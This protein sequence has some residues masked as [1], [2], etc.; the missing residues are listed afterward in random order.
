MKM[1]CN[2]MWVLV[3]GIVLVA[4]A[5]VEAAL[6]D[7]LK[8]YWNFD[9]GSGTT[10]SDIHGDVEGVATLLGSPTWIAGKVGSGAVDFNGNNQYANVPPSMDN[11]DPTYTTSITV[12]AWVRFDKNTG[13][14]YILYKTV[15]TSEGMTMRGSGGDLVCG[16]KMIGPAG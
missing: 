3:C 15:N 14:Q 10:A 12:Q 6:S 8:E 9:E 11:S 4:G 16:L 13:D 2:V 7:G 1:S 5:S